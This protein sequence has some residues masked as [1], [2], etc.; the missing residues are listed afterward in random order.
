MREQI[1]KIAKKGD[2]IEQ[3][4]EK[5]RKYAEDSCLL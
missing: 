3:L 4:R 5:I 1:I 2:N